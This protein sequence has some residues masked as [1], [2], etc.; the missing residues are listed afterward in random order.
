M[1]LPSRLD[2]ADLRRR[3]TAV[4][5]LLLFV[6]VNVA[7]WLHHGHVE[8]A[9]CDLHG[10]LCHVEAGSQDPGATAA[11][12][13][14]GAGDPRAEGPDEEPA[15]GDEHRCVWQELFRERAMPAAPSIGVAHDPRPVPTLETFP[16]CEP[17]ARERLYLLAPKGSP[18]RV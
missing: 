2:R 17:K 5:V 3:R 18:P 10:E 7:G 13:Q 1:A 12:E 6:W 9:P 14:P 11:T 4:G 8:H 15:H 16:A